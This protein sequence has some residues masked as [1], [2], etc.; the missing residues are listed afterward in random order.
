M[1]RDVQAVVGALF[2]SGVQRVTVKD[3]HRTG[4]NL[5]P[6]GIDRRARLVS[7]YRTGPVPGIGD[8]GMAEAVLFLGLHAASGSDGFLAH[9][10]TSHITG[11]MVNG[12]LLPEV[13][14]FS[15]SLA[16]FGVRPVFFSGCPVAC[17][18]AAETVA[19]I[20]TFS[21]DKTGP[22]GDFSAE[23]WRRRLASTAVESVDTASTAVFDPQG[24]FHTLV[25]LRG[26]EPAARKLSERWGFRREGPDLILF[27]DRF[28]ELYRDLIRLSYLTPLIERILPLSIMAFNLRGR[29]GLAWLR[30]RLRET[31]RP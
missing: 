25:R 3:F 7:G 26:G 9:T 24:P 12:R 29:L 10:L 13:A 27:H 20:Q 2:D 17:R 23:R 8:P 11:L 18:Q 4:Y 14:L 22:P 28:R 5:L 1:T 21:I 30:R 6:G 15:N 19:G 16:P 31:G